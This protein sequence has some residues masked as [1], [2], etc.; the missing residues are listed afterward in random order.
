MAYAHHQHIDCMM[1]SLYLDSASALKS[2]SEAISAAMAS[3]YGPCMQR[4]P[5]R[6]VSQSEHAPPPRALAHART[7]C[8][9]FYWSCGA[10]PVIVKSASTLSNLQILIFNLN[11]SKKF[12][13]IL[14]PGG[15]AARTAGLAAQSFGG[16]RGAAAAQSRLW[17]TG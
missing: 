8:D 6:E 11:T 15:C 1:A 7:I 14:A 4:Q 12:I 3:T 9:N 2:L 13:H 5:L 16:R 10:A 17:C